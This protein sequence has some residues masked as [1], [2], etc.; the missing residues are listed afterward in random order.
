MASL[1]QDPG[2]NFHVTFRFGGARF[3]RSLKTKKRR[4]AQAASFRLEENI[5]LIESGRL[6]LP[7]GADIPTF[8]LSDGKLNGKPQ[9]TTLRLGDLLSTYTSSIP[10]DALEPT[11]LKTIG[12]HTRHIVRI[13]G[14]RKTLH[15]I[16][17]KDLQNYITTRSKEP[18]INGFVSAGTIR[19]EI[20]T[21]GS[22]WN[23]AL[24][25]NHV[26]GV[27]PKRG[28]MF[29]KV[30]EKPPFQTWKQIER[31]IAV[32][33]L[34]DAESSELWHSLYLDTTQVDE[35]LE[36]IRVTAEYP[37]L[38][39]MCV[40]AAHTG[41]RRSEF[42]RSQIA[43]FDLENRTVVVRERKRARSKRTTRIVPLTPKLTEVMSTWLEEKEQSPH[44]F[45]E[46]HRVV[47]NR[48]LQRE[49]GCVQPEEASHHLNQVLSGSKWK[50]VVLVQRKLE[51]AVQ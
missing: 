8:L 46:D 39:P 21:F 1:Q 38:Y 40:F 10:S 35:L 36:H 32:G 11:T 16:S 2:G 6:E 5:A 24:S 42:C 13:L 3:K 49:E 23:W 30:T 28:L 50:T 17:T 20:A 34:S 22:L 7:D 45:P 29:P 14:S 9:T 15:S 12:L 19:K 26:T 4:Q 25:Q 41:V 51:F 47:R 31:Q 37:F 43:D 48:K 33:R 44:T 18:G 27:F